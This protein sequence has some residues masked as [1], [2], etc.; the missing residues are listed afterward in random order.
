MRRILLAATLARR[1]L[2][3]GFGSFWIMVVGIALGVAAIAGVGSV[4]DAVLDAVRGGTRESIG[5]DVTLRLF[6]QPATPEQREFLKAA[7]GHSE[8]AELR[9]LAHRVDGAAATL[10]ELKAVDAAYPLYGEVVLEPPADLRAAIALRDG[11]WGAV[12]DP[13]LLAA[14]DLQIG[15]PLRLGTIEA[16]IRG[17]VAQEPDRTLRAFSLGPRVMIGRAA[18]E[19][20]GLAP[21]GAQVYWYSRVRLTDGADPAAW[22]A[23]VERRFPQAGWRIVN[24]DHGVPGVER[25]VLVGRAILVLVGL[26]VLLIG[27]V[28]VGAAV[29]AHLA[30]KRPAIAVL[31]SLGAGE[32]T[33]LTVF[34]FQILLAAVL[35]IGLGVI[36]GAGLPLALMHWAGEW[37]PFAPGTA[38]RPATLA[39]AA[40]FGLLTA[41]LSALWPL[42]QAQRV[43]AR[44]LFLDL[45]GGVAARPRRGMLAAMAGVAVLLLALLLASS[46]MPVASAGF[47]AAAAGAVLLFLGLGRGVAWAA[48]RL[49]PRRPL[50]RLALRSLS[51]RGAATA[52][53]VMALGLSLALLVSVKTIEGNAVAHIEET[54]PREAPAVVFINVPPQRGA[55]LDHA[56]TAIAGVERVQRVPFLHARI[57]H[58]G[59]QAT[60][61][62]RIPAD[63]GWVIRGD[64]GLSWAK[65]PP[66]GARITAGR[67]WDADYRGPPLASLDAEVARRL[68][69]GVGDWLTLNV[70]GAPMEARI[71]N[72]REVDWTRLALDFPVLL[73][74]PAERPP[75]SEVAA[76]WA[77]ADALDAVEAAMRAAFPEAPPIR[78]AP[79]LAALE[80][81]VRGAANVL[82]AVSAVTVA[83]ALLVLA[84]VVTSG[85]GQRVREMV[86]LKVLGAR[87]RQLLAACAIEFTLL[88]AVTAAAATAVGTAAA[89]GV[90]HRLIP[91]GWVFLPAVPATLAAAAV[92]V[93]LA[94]ALILGRRILVRP[95]AEVLRQ[96][97]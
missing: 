58:L 46:G 59:G 18:L 2:R 92:A 78:V 3:G 56:L 95:P 20:S 79:V 25:V 33:V 24:A 4:A 28:G 26:S 35:G 63:L 29:S 67:W 36:A 30:R 76:V 9:P 83:A 93:L 71:A 1:D 39:L 47:A 82:S 55:S 94:T 15:Q 19:A 32:T 75:H 72:L 51:R 90:V 42:G 38:V 14:L 89:W 41:L 6:H 80:T 64:R 53:V 68:G 84:G 70:L 87:P 61:A 85:F 31:K 88:A 48:G 65:K 11:R 86:V 44:R 49:R 69:L 17:V 45:P 96:R 54:L 22:I 73:S 27:G 62:K 5:G 77:T 40:A 8:T 60:H 74:P 50:P 16:E 7:G 23:E 66:D 52:P 91:G 81:M 13:S 37:L 34:L 57:T 43:S 10:V 21:P 12:V 97:A